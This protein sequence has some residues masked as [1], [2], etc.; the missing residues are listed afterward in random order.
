MHIPSWSPSPLAAA[1]ALLCGLTLTAC[2]A[3]GDKSGDCTPGERQCGDT[4][5]F[6]QVCTD[7]ETWLPEACPQGFVCGGGQCICPQGRV[8][9]SGL[10]QP[11]GVLTCPDWAATQAGGCKANAWSTCPEGFFSLKANDCVQPGPL[12]C[13]DGLQR[14]DDGG[15]QPIPNDCSDSQVATPEGCVTPGE[16]DD[17]GAASPFGNLE[18]G[19]N[20][21]F[22]LPGADPQ[23]ADGSPQAPYPDLASAADAVPDGGTLNL[24][25]GL[26]PSGLFAER[27]LKIHGRCPSKVTLTGVTSGFAGGGYGGATAAAIFVSGGP[28]T[29]ISGVTIQLP[30]DSGAAGLV[31]ADCKPVKIFD[32]VILAAPGAAIHAHNSVL[33]LEHVRLEGSLANVSGGAY[34]QA[35]FGV[36]AKDSDVAVTACAFLDGQGVD[37]RAE[38]GSL[39]VEASLFKGRSSE[40][41][42]LPPMGLWASGCK[43]PI[44]VFDSRFD[45]KMTHALKVETCG[46][47]VQGCTIERGVTD[48][49]DNTG[50]AAYFK[51]GDVTFQGNVLRQ[52][53]FA[54]LSLE[55]CTGL[56]DGN[57]IEDTLVSTPGGK[58]GEAL[59]LYQGQSTLTVSNNSIRG[60]WRTGIVVSGGIVTVQQNLVT[61]VQAPDSGQIKSAGISAV[62]KADLTALRNLVSDVQGAGLWYSDATGQADENQIQG[63]AV[64]NLQAGVGILLDRGARTTRGLAGNLLQENEAAGLRCEDSKSGTLS[65]NRFLK[66]GTAEGQPG[67]G[68]VLNNCEGEVLGNQI[69]QNLGGGLYLKGRA[70]AVKGNL[71]E[72]NLRAAY[73]G[74]GVLLDTVDD[75]SVIMSNNTLNNNG[76][77]AVFSQDSFLEFKA[78]KVSGSV[79]VQGLGGYAVLVQGEGSAEVSKSDLEGGRGAGVLVFGNT[80]STVSFSLLHAT[81]G[82]AKGDLPGVGVAGLGGAAVQVIEDRLELMEGAGVAAKGSDVAVMACE[83]VGCGGPAV[84]KENAEP[85]LQGSV[86]VMNG[87][88]GIGGGKVSGP[89]APYPLPEL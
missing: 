10:C 31:V 13:A 59:V 42:P 37:L 3:G 17:C 83:I 48:F 40:V 43:S 66:N 54:S 50:P 25:D 32:T 79:P 47:T 51:G 81:E 65:G 60:A 1:L 16:L 64:K 44:K 69:S 41:V 78:G 74:A 87:L 2:A 77:A 20:T 70:M 27:P 24:G 18:A 53:Q 57:V 21:V 22:V 88:D 8:K 73:R 58:G 38:G 7:D 85:D 46:A 14:A 34:G 26:Y 5:N 23:A 6:V 9:V 33:Q 39:M 75:S 71:V 45:R 82:G 35:G 67:W 63:C 29:E 12:A 84:L 36:M 19:P 80:D 55:G 68:A 89:S 49:T 52:N 62:L 76:F 86:L 28:G 30:K 11:A 4:V 15:C 61:G 56:V 72:G